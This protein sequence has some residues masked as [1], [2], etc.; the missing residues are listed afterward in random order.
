MKGLIL[1][2]V[3]LLTLALALFAGCAD[4]NPI[5]PTNTTSSN[6][7]GNFFTDDPFEEFGESEFPFR[8]A[9]VVERFDIKTRTITLKN[10]DV[11]VHVPVG[12]KAY[13]LPGSKGLDFDFGMISEDTPIRVSG[14]DNGNMLEARLIVLRSGYIPDDDED[15]D[16]FDPRHVVD[17]E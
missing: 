16:D 9:G 6:T 1:N 5:A 15:P 10:E 8:V 4:D 11:R 13:F 12:T 17:G 7:G 3:I 14:V 2:H